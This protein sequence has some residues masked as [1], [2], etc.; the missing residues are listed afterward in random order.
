MKKAISII[1]CA[2]MVISLCGCEKKTTDSEL[3]IGHNTLFD[4]V[5]KGGGY[6]IVRHKETGVCYLVWYNGYQGGITVMLNPDGTPYV[7]EAH[8]GE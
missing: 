2:V 7:W 1:L 6:R 4:S 8:N 3:W 5:E